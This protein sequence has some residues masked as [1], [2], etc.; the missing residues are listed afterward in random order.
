MFLQNTSIHAELEDNEGKC[1][2][3]F[4]ECEAVCEF[5][6]HRKPTASQLAH[7]ADHEEIVDTMPWSHLSAKD[8][9]QIDRAI[10]KPA[11]L[12]KLHSVYDT[13]DRSIVS[14][15]RGDRVVRFLE[16]AELAKLDPELLFWPCVDHCRYECMHQV[17][18]DRE[19]D[20]KFFGKWPFRRVWICQEFLSTLWSIANGLPYLIWYMTPTARTAR[21]IYSAYTIILLLMWTSSAVFHCR[22]CLVTMYFDYFFASAGI[23]GNFSVALDNIAN[24]YRVPNMIRFFFAFFLSLSWIVHVSYMLL[25]DFDFEWN[26]TVAIFFG[27]LGT[28]HWTYWWYTNRVKRSHAWMILP[29]TLGLFPFL[30]LFELNDFPPGEL[31]LADAHSFWHLSTIAMSTLW[32][33]FMYLETKFGKHLDDDKNV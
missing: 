4:V 8:L 21:P 31:G 11:T 24:D 5:A 19:V 25:V 3:L 1:D 13:M 15:S 2:F 32:A 28:L 26:M 10:H 6:C 16:H 14:H 22:D 33:L 27:A 23:I 12:E 9:L 17:V 20:V 7:L 30:I 18:S 29:G